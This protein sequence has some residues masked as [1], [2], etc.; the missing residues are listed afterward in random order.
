[1]NK[2]SLPARTPWALR[3]MAGL[4]FPQRCPVCDR[5]LPFGPRCRAP[6]SL[7]PDP[8]FHAACFQKLAFLE[9]PLCFRCGCPL[10][11]EEQEYCRAC[12][13]QIFSFEQNLPL[14]LYNDAARFSVAHFKYRGRQEFA[15]PYARLWWSR[16][17]EELRRLEPDVLI[18]VPIHRSRLRRRGYNQAAL[19]AYE[20]EK[21]S[22]I[23]CRE[24]LLIRSKHTGAQK[25][26]GRRERLANMEN[27]FRL[28]KRPEGIRCA[29]LV[30]DIFT[31]GS[32]LES[33]SRVLKEAG[34]ERV[35]ALTLCIA[36]T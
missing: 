29:V 5:P 23:P 33:C 31:T 7:S 26:L 4:L 32:T 19:F 6:L 28:Q 20:L 27:A 15:L 24:D 18:P 8:F 3:D 21:L 14:L 22:G 25:E 16:R 10:Q 17:G 12:S 11:Q 13:R 1:M 9:E 35:Y 36:A 30:D 2:D 34:V